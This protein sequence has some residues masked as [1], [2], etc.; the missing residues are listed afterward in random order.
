MTLLYQY[1]DT[2][3]Q[4]FPCCVLSMSS[5][6]TNTSTLTLQATTMIPGSPYSSSP[7]C[8][9]HRRYIL[10]QHRL[11][12]RYHSVH[13]T[14]Y[15]DRLDI[16]TTAVYSTVNPNGGHSSG[17]CGIS[18]MNVKRELA[19]HPSCLLDGIHELGR[20]RLGNL[21]QV[22]LELFLGHANTRVL[23]DEGLGVL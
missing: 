20:S 22:V 13:T 2:L 5:E 7:S 8:G 11:H 21:S 6:R 12:P 4:S 19:S 9:Q 16:N 18:P 15:K 23:D 3:A 17:R 1:Q 14:Q 10:N